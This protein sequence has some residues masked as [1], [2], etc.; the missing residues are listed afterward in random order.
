MSSQ[1]PVIDAI[2]LWQ[3]WASLMWVGAK[4]IETRSWKPPRTGIFLAIHAAKRWQRDEQLLLG[5]RR[6]F[7]ALEPY[8]RTSA[9]VVDWLPRGCFGAIVYLER[10]FDTN[11]EAPAESEDEYWF[12]DYSRNRFG[13]VCPRV[14]RFPE[15]LPAIGRQGF[16]RVDAAEMLAAL[17][18]EDHD[19]L[20][21]FYRHGCQP[22]QHER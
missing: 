8:Y 1:L 5:Q 2:S 6:I 4:K 9:P 20:L 22:R 16:W 13:W 21:N 17:K 15:P 7:N 3:P 11:Y 12:G 10:W 14:W 18:Q 19:D